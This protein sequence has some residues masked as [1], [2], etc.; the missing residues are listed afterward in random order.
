MVLKGSTGE[1]ISITSPVV[2]LDAVGRYRVQERIYSTAKWL[3]HVTVPVFKGCNSGWMSQLESTSK[4]ILSPYFA[5]RRSV[6]VSADKVK[7]LARWATKTWMAYALQFQSQNNPFSKEDYLTISSNKE[8]LKHSK[9]WIYREY[10]PDTQVV[11][12]LRPWVMNGSI[13]VPTDADNTALGVLCV[14]GICIVGLFVPLF[15]HEEVRKSIIP[16]GLKSPW[17]RRLWPGAR[18]MLIPGRPVSGGFTSVLRGWP[19]RIQDAI[20]LPFDGLNQ[21]EIE[22]D[23]RSWRNGIEASEIRARRKGY[24]IDPERTNMPSWW[25]EG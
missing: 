1:R 9:I 22:E 16:E 18:S 24:P 4:S 14:E 21:A 15:L 2:E 20:G 13:P 6:K 11:L 25:L 19:E 8:P 17:V 12:G 10:G 5:N 7:D 23:F 3:P